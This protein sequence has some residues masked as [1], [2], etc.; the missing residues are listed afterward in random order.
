MTK[1]IRDGRCSGL[2][3]AVRRM[4]VPVAVAVLLALFLGAVYTADPP[5]PYRFGTTDPIALSEQPEGEDITDWLDMEQV[6]DQQDGVSLIV[7]N[8][9]VVTVED[10]AGIRWSNAL[11][12]GESNAFSGDDNVICS[13]FTLT[14]KY[15]GERDVT[16]TAYG[17]AVQREQYRVSVQD[18][19]VITEYL[20]G[21]SGGAMIPA[22]IPQERMEQD[23]LPSLE[24]D[25][26]EYLL[27]RYTLYAWETM[28]QQMK[29][30]VQAACPGIEGSPLYFLT[31]GQSSAKQQRIVE[32]LEEA[33]YGEED[34]AEDRLITG[35]S[36]KQF[37]EVYRVVVKYWLDGGDL[38]VE[39]P[40]EEIRFHPDNPLVTIDFSRFF[41]YAGT[42][43]EGYYLIPSESGILVPL[44]GQGN[45]TW[46]YP[47]YGCDYTKDTKK[48]ITGAVPFPVFGMVRGSSGFLAVVEEGAEI[49][50]LTLE[51]AEGGSNLYLSLSVVDFGNVSIA[52]S[53]TST[54]YAC[55]AYTGPVRIRY[56]LLQGEKANYS[57]MATAYREDLI[58][59]GILKQGEKPSP[60]ALIDIIG[61]VRT[62]S[63]SA[64]FPV[65]KP[66]VL[67][68]VEQCRGICEDLDT[69]GVGAYALQLSGFNKG[70]LYRQVP[71]SYTLEKALGTQEEWLAFME[72]AEKK[73]C[74]IY[75]DV[76]FGF[77]YYDSFGDGYSQRKMTAKAL[78][79]SAATIVVGDKATGAP[80]AGVQPIQIVS[81]RWFGKFAEQY[82]NVLH[83][84]LG[85]GLGDS[86]LHI[87]SDFT[88]HATVG[89]TQ[90]AVHLQEAAEMLAEHRNVLLSSPASYLLSTASLVENILTEESQ[91]PLGRTKIP[92]SSMVLHGYMPYASDPVNTAPDPQAKL[93]QAI[94]SG[95]IPQ[96]RLAGHLDMAIMDTEY[97]YL[98]NIDYSQWKDD[99]LA[100]IAYV[101]EALRG[102]QGQIIKAH[103]IRGDLRRITYED[104]TVLY[105]N[106]GAAEG[107]WDGIVIP[108]C[109]YR[110][111][112]PS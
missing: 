12:P 15:A 18:G 68:S 73:G 95:S 9:G 7:S 11:R 87:Q 58:R 21:E 94:E 103:E 1:K 48:M 108:S 2:R 53:K 40:F 65:E 67:T 51:T 75:L 78:D 46:R 64:L 30:T 72:A 36:T 13:P 3:K 34:Y 10:A 62:S 29:E 66:L 91:G 101:Q 43:E 83:P 112:E 70:G 47:F 8:G 4:A 104:G 85:I 96:Y 86:S 16:Y 42:G 52:P 79:N 92:F 61:H 25:D 105:V 38:M 69:A 24:S 89:R 102:L 60:T 88:P 109:Q 37:N 93:L 57:W 56:H 45:D 44:G 41:G 31:D 81:S 23:I 97:N 20:L 106:Y 76:N 17:D 28:S 26:A 63:Q 6:V 80:A 107:N 74:T 33:A 100:G 82:D 71:D 98:Y 14:Y 77:Y 111:T 54:V 27:R 35:E 5:T 32:V 84:G 59:E 90:A 99:M 55:D 19:T 110:R 49:A 39:I 22:G 50:T